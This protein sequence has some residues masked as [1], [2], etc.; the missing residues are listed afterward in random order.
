MSLFEPF[1]GY[2]E[3]RCT[4]CGKLITPRQIKRRHGGYQLETVREFER[5]MTCTKSCAQERERRQQ[6]ARDKKRH[7]KPQEARRAPTWQ[8]SVKPSTAGR[9]ECL[10]LLKAACEIHPDLAPMLAGDVGPDIFE[11]RRDVVVA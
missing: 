6:A 9:E 7:Q 1:K 5:R 4:V 11:N 3:R 10:E 8:R 2:P